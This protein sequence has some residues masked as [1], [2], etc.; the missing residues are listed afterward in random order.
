[1]A[2]AGR[3]ASLLGRGA[4]AYARAQM[5]A[6]RKRRSP[7]RVPGQA[8]AVLIGAYGGEHVGDAAILGGVLL[9]LHR[10]RGLRRAVVASTRPD[11]TRRW[12]S[13]L[14]LPVSVD[15]IAY[16]PDAISTALGHADLLV[17]AGGPLM[18]L[19]DV[20]I[21]HL[22]AAA[23][24]TRRALPFVL[25][26]IGYGPFRNRASA[27]AA[28][29]ILELATEVTVRGEDAGRRLRGLGCDA[30]VTRDPA[31]DYLET[32]RTLTRLK[33]TDARGITALL[34][35]SPESVRIGINLRPLWKKYGAGSATRTGDVEKAFLRWTA[36][37]LGAASRRSERPLTFVFWPMNAD[38][39]GFSDLTVAT[40]LRDLL[41][42][43]VT[44]RIWETEPDVDAVLALLR[45][46]DAAVTMRF[47]AS[48]FALSQQVPAIGVDYQLDGTG[49]VGE[50]FTAHPQGEA[51]SIQDLTPG[52]LTERLLHIAGTPVASGRESTGRP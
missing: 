12:V 21:R 28:H 22:N 32:R 34:E 36:A 42:H 23:S 49:K 30:V 4:A 27:A 6:R 8:T 25:E 17:H 3:A 43:E 45:G 10:S 52:R 39:Y 7:V 37:E 40:R 15:V 41:D 20:L 29:A 48:V 19:P 33:E 16:E 31:F 46:L 50:L 9:R 44:F 11:R 2:L 51:L 1:V 13:C 14:E 5:T 26:G 35:G 24:A 47:H 18:D 38:Q